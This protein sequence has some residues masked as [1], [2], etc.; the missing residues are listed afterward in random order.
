MGRKERGISD[1]GFR[2]E[3]E[4]TETCTL[5]PD[6]LRFGAWDLPDVPWIWNWV[7]E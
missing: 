3:S 4:K 6:A 5:K 2:N 1:F 7:K